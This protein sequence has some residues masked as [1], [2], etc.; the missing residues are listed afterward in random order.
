VRLAEDRRRRHSDDLYPGPAIRDFHY[1]V[2]TVGAEGMSV[3]VK[4]LPKGGA[5]FG[6]LD[7][8][9]MAWPSVGTGRI[10]P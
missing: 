8:F 4:G 5:S 1:M 7:R 6:L 2:C 9:E 3:D 10:R